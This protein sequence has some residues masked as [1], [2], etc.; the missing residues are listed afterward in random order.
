MIKGQINILHGNYNTKLAYHIRIINKNKHTG[1][2]INLNKI[3][4]RETKINM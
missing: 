2:Q 1:K 4:I 3:S